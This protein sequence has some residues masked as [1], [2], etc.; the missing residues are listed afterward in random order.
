[1]DLNP[2][3]LVSLQEDRRYQSPLYCSSCAQRKERSCEDAVRRQALAK[4]KAAEREVSPE[5]SSASTLIL[6]I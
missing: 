2:I 4:H 5:T 6:A 1:M 3:G